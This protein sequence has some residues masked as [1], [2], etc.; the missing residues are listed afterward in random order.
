MKIEFESWF[1]KEIDDTGVKIYAFNIIPDISV[2]YETN[3]F[4]S[5]CIMFLFWTL[6]FE[7]PKNE[8]NEPK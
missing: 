1:N 2:I 3:G 5:I 7:K 4:L 6:A 8:Q